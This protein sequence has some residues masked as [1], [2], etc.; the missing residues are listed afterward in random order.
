MAFMELSQAYR[1]CPVC[2]QARQSRTPIRPFRCHACGHTTFFGPVTAVGA[3]IQNAKGEVLLIERA[4]EPGIGKLGMP[5]G[6]VDPNEGAEDA[7][8]REVLEEVGITVG[9]LEFVSTS[10]N[11]YHYHGIDIP[12]VDIF[13][14]T[15]AETHDIEHDTAEVSNWMWTDLTVEVLDGMAFRSNRLA[16]ERFRSKSVPKS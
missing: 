7:L 5:G 14:S 1:Y 3:I 4:K 16:L 2:G 8:R 11:S 12:V 9:P 15:Q 13:F 10:P 6:F